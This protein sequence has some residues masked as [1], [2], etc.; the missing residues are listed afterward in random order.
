M[1]LREL[2]RSSGT[3]GNRAKR[4]NVG[5]HCSRGWKCDM[6]HTFI[7]SQSAA[8]DKTLLINN[9]LQSHR[10]QES[11]SIF[12]QIPVFCVCVLWF[13][14]KFHDGRD[15]QLFGGSKAAL[16][17]FGRCR[18]ASASRRAGCCLSARWGTPGRHWE[19]AASALPEWHT[20]L[21]VGINVHP[22]RIS[23]GHWPRI[24]GVFL[25]F[26]KSCAILISFVTPSASQLN[27]GLNE[28]HSSQRTRS[29][30]LQ[31]GSLW[32]LR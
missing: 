4:L 9:P 3:M 28:I 29:K 31:L 16:R 10:S 17:R 5:L 12:K 24:Y 7:Y 19:P 1:W 15:S 22:L 27:K 2:G 25:S 30:P 11:A 32:L 8:D 20:R 18:S 23:E 26:F 21:S 14:Y 13:C 6:I